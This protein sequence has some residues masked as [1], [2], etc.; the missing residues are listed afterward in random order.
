MIIM[1]ALIPENHTY[2]SINDAFDNDSPVNR[3]EK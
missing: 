3:C 2:E 1:S